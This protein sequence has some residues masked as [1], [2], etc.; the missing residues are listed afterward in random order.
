MGYAPDQAEEFGGELA[1]VDDLQVA[2]AAAAAAMG[3]EEE[4]S[5]SSEGACSIVAKGGVC[6]PRSFKKGN[7]AS[8]VW[9]RFYVILSYR[10]F[11]RLSL[12]ILL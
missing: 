11:I 10:S 5:S 1:S 7:Q 12:I 6:V 2:A 4:T 3:E 9:W 8:V